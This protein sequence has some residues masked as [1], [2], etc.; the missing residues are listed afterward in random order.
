L[1][2]GFGIPP[3]EALACGVPVVASH[4]TSLPEVLGDAALYVDPC[5]ADEI[6]QAIKR[7]LADPQLGKDL[8]AKGYRRLSYYTSER[9]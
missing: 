8:R 6:A 1:Y 2:E 3:V 5:S 7:I 9:V 4:H